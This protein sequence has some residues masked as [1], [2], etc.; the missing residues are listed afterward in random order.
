MLPKKWSKLKSQKAALNRN[1][2]KL[3]AAVSL[4]K[5]ITQ[6]VMYKHDIYGKFRNHVN[7]RSNALGIK[8]EKFPTVVYHY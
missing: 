6:T 2:Q 1:R 4:N 8:L 5:K 7:I 3:F